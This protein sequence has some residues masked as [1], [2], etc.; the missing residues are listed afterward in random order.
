[1]KFTIEYNPEF[2]DDLV[3]AV[4]WY[5]NKLIGLGDRFLDKVKK[6]TAKLST[7]ALLFSVKYENIRCMRIEKF[8]YLVHYQVDEQTLTVKVEAL[9]HTS[10]NPGVWHKRALD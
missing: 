9:F 1:M 7:S 4:D 6:Q 3:Q 8:P 5:N 10:R 2:F